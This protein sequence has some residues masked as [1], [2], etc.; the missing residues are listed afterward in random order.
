MLEV[1]ACVAALGTLQ[2]I[3][4][5]DELASYPCP[6]GTPV[7]AGDFN[8]DGVEDLVTVSVNTVRLQL[9]RHGVWDPCTSQDTYNFEWRSDSSSTLFGSLSGVGDINGDGYADIALSASG[10]GD[11]KR[12]YIIFGF[13]VPPT[14]QSVV[15]NSSVLAA[16]AGI[17]LHLPTCLSAT[18]FSTAH[19]DF[20]GDGVTDVAF[21]NMCRA[22]EVHATLIV[23]GAQNLPAREV[24][25]ISSFDGGAGATWLE[26]PAY[27]RLPG[28]G[29]GFSLT[30]L[31]ANGDG[32]ADL[33]LPADTDR[34]STK[35]VYVVLG[36][37]QSLP[38]SVDVLTLMDGVQGFE[39][40][41]DF[42][43]QDEGGGSFA[44][45]AV[46]LNGDGLEDLVVPVSLANSSKA[47]C[48]VFG[49][50]KPF[51]TRI[52]QEEIDG[53]NGYF[54]LPIP[55]HDI[56]NTPGLARRIG[57][58]EEKRAALYYQ[59]YFMV[60]PS[61]PVTYPRY[62]D[63]DDLESGYA[64][65]FDS[66]EFWPIVV[67]LGDFIGNG[68][69]QLGVTYG[70]F[71]DFR[72]AVAVNPVYHATGAP[73]TTRPTAAP[74][75]PLPETPGPNS[76]TPGLST[77]GILALVFVMILMACGAGAWAY[78]HRLPQKM[79]LSLRSDRGERSSDVPMRETSAL[80]R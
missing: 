72:T 21:G 30:A 66:S 36:S 28:G 41:L 68:R 63:L 43:E 79:R 53:T 18:V 16:G 65:K 49:S 17:S 13:D 32:V 26:G 34:D 76:D 4:A 11:V 23:W 27:T 15:V 61:A 44:T 19:A 80:V 9:G 24:V 71:G 37:R 75:T 78:A 2:Y 58:M 57:R 46:D 20:N 52:E 64:F 54:A 6:S 12:A 3:P 69:S 50:A 25:D 59:G 35:A 7:A 56:L 51:P 60:E 33:A 10:T 38:L 42:F 45:C 74:E 48:V 8:N 67:D 22:E 1:V 40:A 77:G 39:L 29:F 55:S 14:P 47:A 70:R 31:D 62:F 5:A 73:P